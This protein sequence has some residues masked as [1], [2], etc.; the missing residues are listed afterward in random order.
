MRDRGQ[1]IIK[2]SPAQS[3]LE[4]DYRPSRSDLKGNDNN[5]TGNE[6]L[7][8]YREPLT[9]VPIEKT[10]QQGEKGDIGVGRG[11]SVEAFAKNDIT[12]KQ[13]RFYHKY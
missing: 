7:E 1:H 5:V 12:C 13:L 8:N 3:H 6:H 4:V 11:S 10:A 2:L 9:K